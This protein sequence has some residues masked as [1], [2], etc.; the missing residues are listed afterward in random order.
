MTRARAA[1]GVGTFPDAAREACASTPPLLTTWRF[2]CGDGTASAQRGRSTPHR[3]A[4]RRAD[5]L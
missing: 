3:S 2:G 4:R 5:L 1:I